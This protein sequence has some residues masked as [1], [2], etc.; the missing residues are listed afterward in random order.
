MA[1]PVWHAEPTM[2]EH[3]HATERERDECAAEA[4]A[5]AAWRTQALRTYFTDNREDVT[6]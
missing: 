1:G 6:A 3:A 5:T 2:V 4:F